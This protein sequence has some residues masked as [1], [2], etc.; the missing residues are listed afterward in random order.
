M[1]IKDYQVV[2]LG[3]LIAIGS[4]ISTYILSNAIVEFQKLQNQTIRVTGSANQTVTSDRASWTINFRTVKPSLKEGYAKISAD[5]KKIR[6]FLSDNGIDEKATE[7]GAIGSYENYKRNYNG[8]TTNEIESYN[9]YQSVTVKSN[10]INKLTEVAKTVDVLV[11]QDIDLTSDSVQYFVSNIDDIKVKMVGEAAKNAKER[12][13][14]MVKGT[15][16]R[17]GAMNSARMGV[18]QIV[19]V[20]STEVND[21]GINDTSSIEK[22]VVA[23]VTATFTVK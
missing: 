9:V 23:T 12:A 14:S 4:V 16:G 10:D 1:Q 5:A 18:F 13:K 7:F 19:P 2:L 22:K 11:N 8:N 3:V 15:N 21:Y 6:K 20:D 17:I